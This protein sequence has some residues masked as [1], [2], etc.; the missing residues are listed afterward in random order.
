MERLIPG[1]KPTIHWLGGGHLPS[2]QGP[3]SPLSLYQLIKKSYDQA[4]TQDKPKF[5]ASLILSSLS[6]AGLKL[7]HLFQEYAQDHVHTHTHSQKCCTL[8]HTVS[9]VKNLGQPKTFHD[10]G[11][12]FFSVFS[13]L[14][15][16]KINLFILVKTYPWSVIVIN[17]DCF[18]LKP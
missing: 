6:R 2:H 11:K 7:Q 13:Y 3:T 8:T 17:S 15:N 1:L 18:Y 9:F 12:L 5:Y 10:L 4:K 14:I 16:W